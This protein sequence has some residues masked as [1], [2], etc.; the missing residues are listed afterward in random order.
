MMNQLAALFTGKAVRAVFPKEIYFGSEVGGLGFSCTFSYSGTFD[1]ALL[2][3]LEREIQEVPIQ[4]MEM[5][6]S[7]AADLFSHLGLEKLADKVRRMEGVVQVARMG[8]FADIYEGNLEEWGCVALLGFEQKNRSVKIFGRG[9]ERKDQRRDFLKKFQGYQSASYWGKELALFEDNLWLPRGMTLKHLLEDYWRA[10]LQEGGLV[11]VGGEVGKSPFKNY[12]YWKGGEDHVVGKNLEKWMEASL[13]KFGLEVRGLKLVDPLGIEREGPFFQ[14]GKGSLFGNL[15]TFI[16]TLLEAYQGELPF[17]L[18]PEQMRLI[19]MEGADP[20]R[21]KE[22]LMK[23]KIRT[24]I[25]AKEGSLGEK[26][27]R[28]LHIKVPYVIFFG[29]REEAAKSVTIRAIGSK[30]DDTITYEEFETFVQERR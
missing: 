30:R 11:E 17:W 16:Y 28:A 22:I 12:G 8:D 19:V 7:N 18:A 29:K 4:E 15:E 21:V 27:Q 2:E 23:A 3:H 26:L 25:E 6:G 9:F 5:L 14:R 13:Q 10:S 24:E 1:S 20:K